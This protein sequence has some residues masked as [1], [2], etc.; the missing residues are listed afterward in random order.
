[1]DQSAFL[2]FGFDLIQKH[3]ISRHE[4]SNCCF[5]RCQR[6]GEPSYEQGK[7]ALFLAEVFDGCAKPSLVL[8]PEPV[9]FSKNKQA[10]KSWILIEVIFQV[11]LQ[12]MAGNVRA[13]R[14]E[15]GDRSR[16]FVRDTPAAI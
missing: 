3:V 1:M 13:E 9:A 2:R 6:I 15:N 10:C 7:Y 5:L 12:F 4:C 11:A 16:L 14:K 8:R